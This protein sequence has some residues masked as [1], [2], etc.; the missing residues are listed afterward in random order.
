MEKLNYKYHNVLVNNNDDRFPQRE[1]IISIIMK[2][3]TILIMIIE[4]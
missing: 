4:K 3:I 1:K 2:M